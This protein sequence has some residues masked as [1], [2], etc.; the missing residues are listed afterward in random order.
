MAILFE[1]F[2]GF[3][4]YLSK[5][6]Y[7]TF[8][9]GLSVNKGFETARGIYLLMNNNTYIWY[10][11]LESI[12]KMT[13]HILTSDLNS[14]NPNKALTNEKQYLGNGEAPSRHCELCLE[15]F[16][17]EYL[18]GDNEGWHFVNAIVTK[19]E[20][21]LFIQDVCHNIY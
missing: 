17:Q 5:F 1:Y 6:L 2:G 20:R 9:I 3:A 10:P 4:C 19:D 15:Q 11:T 12:K 7:V 8:L 18:D 16:E 13:P 14:P 21:V